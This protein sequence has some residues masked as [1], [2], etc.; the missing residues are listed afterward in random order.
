MWSI[1]EAASL[2]VHVTVAEAEGMA[3]IGDAGEDVGG[4]PTWY[5]RRDAAIDAHLEVVDP[6]GCVGGGPR[7]LDRARP[8]ELTGSRRGHG[9]GR[10]CR[11]DADCHGGACRGS[12]PVERLHDDRVRTVRDPGESRTR[13][14]PG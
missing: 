11:V 4:G 9:G 3:P 7:E 8:E 1:P 6:R 5:G 13:R 10:Q 2:A 12:G 14:G